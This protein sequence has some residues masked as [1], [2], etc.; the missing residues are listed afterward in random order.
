VASAVRANADAG[1]R[2]A[3]L[4]V[5][6]YI[7]NCVSNLLERSANTKHCHCADKGDQSRFCKPGCAADHIRFRDTE[8]EM[9]IRVLF[10]KQA[11]HRCV[12]EVRVHYDDFIV[13]PA[14]FDQRFGVGRS[15]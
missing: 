7:A 8:V 4:Y 6:V 11:A 3:E 13:C 12:P 14:E 5:G 9:A 10:L 15:H 2:K 1:V